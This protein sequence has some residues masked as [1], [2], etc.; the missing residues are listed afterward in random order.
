M[1]LANRPIPRSERN[2]KPGKVLL[3]LYKH[4]S[5]RSSGKNLT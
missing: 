4:K 3:D 5:S 1:K 2:K